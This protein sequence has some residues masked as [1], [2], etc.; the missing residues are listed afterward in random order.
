MSDIL[1][2]LLTAADVA[3][4]AGV[5]VH[6]LAHRTDV[7]AGAGWIAL[8][9]LS[10]FIGSILYFLFGINRIAR[11]ASR[12]RRSHPA[13]AERSTG[14]A[15]HL[16]VEAPHLEPLGILT[17]RA[18][19]L[20]LMTGNR[21]EPLA[22]GD[23]AYPAMLRAI[24]EATVSVILSSYIFRA[25]AAGLPFIDALIQAH[26]RG[27]DVR[28]LVDGIGAGYFRSPAVT[29]LAEARVPVARFLHS[30]MP[31]RMAFLNLRLHKKILVVDGRLG[32]TGGLNIGAENIASRRKGDEGVRDIHFAVSGPVVRDLSATFE[33]D[34]SFTTGDRR[35]P[36]T[37]ANA[38]GVG[39]ALA[40]GIQS[41]PDDD[42]AKIETIMIGA[43]N[44][45]HTRIRL[46]TPYFLPDRTLQSALA[47]ASL[48]GVSVEIT[49]PEASNHP[50]VDWAA[51]AQIGVLLE[52][53]C[54]V[55]LSRGPLDHSKIMTVDGAWSLVGSA[56]WDVRSLR[57]NFE[58]ELEVW[59]RDFVAKLN[60][61]LDEKVARAR[62]LARQELTAAGPLVRIRN[63]A[64]RLLLP[65][66]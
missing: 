21:L 23:A 10:P 8:A 44:A 52:R 19:G 42:I 25:D 15:P 18:S 13:T 16:A 28:V 41:G 36:I 59:D 30:W 48:R 55:H 3:S 40:R 12:L 45:A 9:W 22:N 14:T 66:L 2:P 63:A 35:R 27:V 57:L 38:D 43:V 24:D 62:R 65:Y 31:W 5:T 32:F 26:R 4:A 51:R 53:G 11:R 33:Q 54:T 46:T 64:A 47:F 6:V 29:A 49:I 34:W 61:I 37:P 58:F 1:S 56:N 50:L 17:G 20:P 60:A 7:R 39:P